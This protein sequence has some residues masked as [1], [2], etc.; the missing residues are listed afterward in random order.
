MRVCA[1]IKRFITNARRVSSRVVGP[2]TTDEIERQYKFWEKRV[3]QSCDCLDDK[4]RLNLQEDHDGI[5]ECGGRIHG[6]YPVYLSD[7]HLFTTKLVEDAHLQ[8][9]HGK[10]GMTMARVRERN[11]VPRLRQLTHRIIKACYGCRRFQVKAVQQ[12]PPGLL[13]K[14]R[15]EGSRPFEAVGVDFAGPLKYKRKKKEQGKAYVLLYACSLTRPLYLE[16]MLS[17]DTQRFM[18]SFKQLIARKGRPSKVYSD[19][20][21]TFVAAAKWLCEAQRDERFN[22]F[23]S[24]N[25]VKWQFNLSRAP[26]WG[27]QFEGLI[28]L[29]KRALHKTIGNGLLNWDV[30]LDVEVALNDRPLSYMEDDIQL[31]ILTPNSMLFVDKRSRGKWPLGI[32]EK[33]YN[34]RDGVVC[35]VK[36]RAGKMY[37][38]RA[39]NHLYPLELSCD[40]VEPTSVPLDPRTP[41]FKPKQDTAVAAEQCIKEVTELEV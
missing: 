11:C 32:V 7:K 36:L 41:A 12:P 8:T 20:A 40:R 30:L 17:L 34:G 24:K 33:L 19:N 6:H 39:V 9:L 2:L 14:D 26:W 35:A 23:L 18:E 1:W 21:K 31:P 38:E 37:L 13:P 15:T 16:L 4:G 3:Q 25:Q 28:G 10:V 22:E 29:V 27:S 5:M